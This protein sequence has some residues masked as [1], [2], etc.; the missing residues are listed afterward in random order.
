MVVR[1]RVRR[2]DDAHR[3]PDSASQDE[4]VGKNQSIVNLRQRK[5][6]WH[7]PREAR[8][9]ARDSRS[10]NTYHREARSENAGFQ[11]R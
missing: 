6:F 9:Q 4:A 3:M 1:T 2:H 10:P 5:R 7:P 8:W 11:Y